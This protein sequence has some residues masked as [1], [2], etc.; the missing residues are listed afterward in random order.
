MG[1]TTKNASGEI[2][3]LKATESG[4]EQIPHKII[5][6]VA[7]VVSAAQDGAWSVS[8][9]SPFVPGTSA[10][11]LGKQED[12]IHSSG[13]V[14]V[15]ALAV[16]NDAGTSLVSASGD[17][18]PLQVDATGALRV[19]GAMGTQYAE[20]AIHSSGDA[21]TMALVVRKDVAAALAGT[22]GDYTALI[23]DASGRLWC[24]ATLA[25]GS[26]AI[27]KL[28]ANSGVIIGAVEKS[29]DWGVLQET[30]SALADGTKITIKTRFATSASFPY[31][32]VAAVPSKKI[33]VLA[34]TFGHTANGTTTLQD[35]SGGTALIQVAHVANSTAVV[36][37]PR[38]F[39]CETTAGNALGA[40]ATAGTSYV[41]VQYMEV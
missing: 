31:T 35:G 23:T 36:A 34:A 29:G 3:T 15:M 40:T 19:T 28:A 38:G 10:T 24:N 4:G 32:V 21:G 7:G 9:V 33:R 13:D 12:A 17:Y 26:N 25:A 18:A 16:R 20:D 6:S 30:G 27:G 39:V 1:I 11:A 8:I 37:P 41:W 22:D 14:G 5:D 2:V